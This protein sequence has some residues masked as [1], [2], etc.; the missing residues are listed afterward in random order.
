[1]QFRLLPAIT[2]GFLFMLQPAPGSSRDQL[3]HE[4]RARAE[5]FYK[6]HVE[7]NFREAEKLVCPESRNAFYATQKRTYR[8]A[9]VSSVVLAEDSKSA[10]VVAL[11]EGEF[12]VGT[13]LQVVKAPVPSHWQREKQGW[14]Y[15]LAPGGAPTAGTV[16]VQSPMGPM[17]LG[18]AGPESALPPVFGHNAEAVAGLSSG[19]AFSKD[20][21][22]FK[23]QSRAEDSIEIRNGLSGA[24]RV[25][26]DCPLLKSFACSID[27]ADIQGGGVATLTVVYDPS[28]ASAGDYLVRSL[29]LIVQ[30]FQRKK[31]IAIL[32]E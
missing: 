10:E 5:R 29:F 8:S 22:R 31:E 12:T 17:V 16:V 26:L 30:P 18:P 1:M 28:K 3:E 15:Y 11:L 14:C 20:S 32:F 23:R 4:V 19:V 25:E 9:P 6:L 24:V 7:G 13:G 27:R 2:L 21:L